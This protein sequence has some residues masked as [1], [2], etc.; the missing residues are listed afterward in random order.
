[1]SDR[2]KKPGKFRLLNFGRKW[3]IPHQLVHLFYSTPPVL[4]VEQNFFILQQV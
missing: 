1:M 3:E 4:D 2:E